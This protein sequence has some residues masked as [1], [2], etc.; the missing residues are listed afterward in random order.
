LLNS[1]TKAEFE[2]LLDDAHMKRRIE[3]GDKVLEREA[4]RT[5]RARK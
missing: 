5:I 1:L 4:R 3:T 2:T